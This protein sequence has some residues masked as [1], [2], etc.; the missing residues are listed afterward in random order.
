MSKLPFGWYCGN[1]VVNHLMYADEIGIFS[2]SA[3]GLQKTINMRYA[4]GCDSDIIFN[5]ST[6]QVM[7]FDTMKYGHMSNIMLGQKTLNMT[8]SYTYLG[9]IITYNWCDEAGI[10]T[11]NL[12]AVVCVCGCVS[13]CKI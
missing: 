13:V 6:S 3:K 12:A 8:K 1:T 2:P 4:N 5:S 7:F 10:H 11:T 9:H